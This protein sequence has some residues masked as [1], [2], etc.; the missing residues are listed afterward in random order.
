[1]SVEDLSY[2]IWDRIFLEVFPGSSDGKIKDVLNVFKV[3]L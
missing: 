1:M 2:D 3:Q